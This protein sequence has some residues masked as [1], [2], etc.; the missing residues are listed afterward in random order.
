MLS[1]PAW[2]CTSGLCPLVHTLSLWI[3]GY[4]TYYV[5]FAALWVP[6]YFLRFFVRFACTFKIIFPYFLLLNFYL[7]SSQ[8]ANR[9]YR[10]RNYSG[11]GTK[12]ETHKCPH[13]FSKPESDYIFLCTSPSTYCARMTLIVTLPKSPDRN[14]KFYYFSCLWGVHCVLYLC[15]FIY[16]CRALE[17]EVFHITLVKLSFIAK[18]RQNECKVMQHHTT[19]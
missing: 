10:C 19:V 18:G 2:W 6:K 11:I 17:R 8:R 15:L 4:P 9:V 1:I 14:N 13:Y 12:L 7:R 3:Q 16:V 5:G